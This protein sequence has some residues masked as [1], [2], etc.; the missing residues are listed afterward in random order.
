MSGFLPRVGGWFVG[1]RDLAGEIIHSVL[2]EV[3]SMYFRQLIMIALFAFANC[4][5]SVAA[6]SLTLLVNGKEV[7][8]EGEILIE[9]KDNSLYF[10]EVDGKICYETKGLRVG[11]IPADV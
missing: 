6:D 11:T 2:G 3:E 9:A 4:C 8:L 10:R 5:G 1:I 7:Q